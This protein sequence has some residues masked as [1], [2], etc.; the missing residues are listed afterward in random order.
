MSPGKGKKKQPISW[1]VLRRSGSKALLITEKGVKSDT[2]MDDNS[3]EWTSDIFS[4]IGQ[5]TLDM[6]RLL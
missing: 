1:L 4:T 2:F 6:Q 5:K 3:E